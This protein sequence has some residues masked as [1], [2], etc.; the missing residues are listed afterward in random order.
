MNPFA[1]KESKDATAKDHEQDL[2]SIL[3]TQERV[4]LTLL[5]ANITELMRKQ[6]EDTFDASAT[7]AKQSQQALHITNKNPN[8][9]DKGCHEETEE[10][11]KARKLREKREK[12]LSAPKM[13]ELKKDAINFFD[14]WRDSVILRVGSVVNNPK[15]LTEEQKEKAT[16]EATPSSEPP[17]E[18]KVLS[19]LPFQL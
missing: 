11:E 19:E 3:T 7:S 10:E 17:A 4:Q 8:I 18:P 6:I 15:E 9:E 14:E 1:S 13:L 16:V 2:A 5:L 12:E